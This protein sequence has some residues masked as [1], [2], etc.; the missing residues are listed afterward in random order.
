MDARDLLARSPQA[1]ELLKPY[2]KPSSL[3]CLDSK[4]NLFAKLEFENPTGSFK[5]RPALYGVLS[6]R[7][8]AI[9]SGVLAASSGNFAQA[10]AHAG[11]TLGAKTKI[12]MTNRTSPFKVARTKAFGGEV[13]FSGDTFESREKLTQELRA[14]GGVYLH[15]FD[16]PETILGDASL[17]YELLEQMDSDFDVFI[18]CSGGGLLSAVA[19][20]LK[21]RRPACRVFGTQPLNNSSM[22]KSFRFGD[23]VKVPAF[24]SVCDSLI[25]VSPGALTFPL[26]KRYVDDIISPSEEQILQALRDLWASYKVKCET[27]CATSLAALDM[28]KDL[29]SS[30]RVKILVLTGANIEDEKWKEWVSHE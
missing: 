21:E 26:I 15:P 30:S 16:C 22:E 9:Q 11:K 10:V 14:E 27:G 18:P 8:R 7:E 12:V 24:D 19:T 20:V 25:A 2:L 29:S 23:R 5:D 13:I 4:Q 17:A 3:V 6:H 1:R 28:R